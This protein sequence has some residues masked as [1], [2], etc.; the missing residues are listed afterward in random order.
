MA[1]TRAANNGVQSGSLLTAFPEVLRS[2]VTVVTDLIRPSTATHPGAAVVVRGESLNIP[3]RIHHECDDT[4]FPQLNS[5]QAA[6]YACVLT[7]HLDG[8]VRQRQIGRLATSP[9]PW[10]APFIVHLCGEYVI[11]ILAEIEAN[12][13]SMDQCVYGAFFR[14]NPVFMKRTHDRMISYWDC[15]YRWLY[16]RKL[17][18]V[19]FRVFER[20]H[21]WCSSS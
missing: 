16:K 15:Y 2:E 6:I 20:F 10:I 19:G 11:E 18:Y 8:H 9:E 5:A 13:P 1:S 21:E 4:L 3:Y 14:E 12:L 7:R 17:D